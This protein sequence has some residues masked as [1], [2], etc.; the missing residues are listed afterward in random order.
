MMAWGWLPLYQN[1][2]RWSQN[3]MNRVKTPSLYQP[4]QLTETV[5]TQRIG[6]QPCFLFN[7]DST[8]SCQSTRKMWKNINQCL[9]STLCSLRKKVI[10]NLCKILLEL[11]L[12]ILVNE[13]SRGEKPLFI[14]FG[15]CLGSED[16]G[17]RETGYTRVPTFQGLRIL[18]LSIGSV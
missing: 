16:D 10:C 12:R 6:S 15:P 3:R 7:G 9:L 14:C 17:N 4:N 1:Q 2:D 18:A 8:V 13:P 5:G 11:G